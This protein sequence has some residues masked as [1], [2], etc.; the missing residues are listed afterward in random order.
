M[1][2]KIKRIDELRT[3]LLSGT[4]LEAIESRHGDRQGAN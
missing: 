2:E 3:D 1:H 4:D